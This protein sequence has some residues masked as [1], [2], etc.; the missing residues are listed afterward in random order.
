MGRGG[1][2][3]RNGEGLAGKVEGK[4]EESRAQGRQEFPEMAGAVLHCTKCR[5]SCR[6][7]IGALAKASSRGQVAEGMGGGEMDGNHGPILCNSVWG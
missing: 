3:E 1:A 5:V 6:A 4:P 2:S 7:L